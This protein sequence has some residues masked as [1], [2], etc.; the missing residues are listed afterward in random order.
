[1]ALSRKL[2]R[3]EDLNLNRQVIKKAGLGFSPFYS[4]KH[5]RTET[6]GQGRALYLLDTIALVV[7]AQ[8]VLPRADQ[9]APHGGVQ[10]Q[11]FTTTIPRGRHQGLA[12]GAELLIADRF[13]MS[14]EG[15]ELGSG[16]NSPHQICQIH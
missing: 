15:E 3:R 5:K 13:C 1:M 16:S 7:Q 14:A 9:G 4:R 8:P 12:I 10:R 6:P 2:K 11:N